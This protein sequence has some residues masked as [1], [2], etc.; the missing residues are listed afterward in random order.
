MWLSLILAG[1]VTP[2]PVTPSSSAWTAKKPAVQQAVLARHG[3]HTQIDSILIKRGYALVH[4][5]GFHDVLRQ[6]G[7]KWQTTCDLSKNDPNASVLQ[8]Q[9]G[10]P[11]PIAEVLASEEPVNIL[12]GQGNFSAALSAEQ[13]VS[14]SVS[15]SPTQSMRLQQLRTLNE[16]MQIQQITRSQAIAQW[17]QLEY[18]WFLP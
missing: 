13:G 8:S 15:Q 3:P 7:T 14:G 12:A 17:S 10:V 9:C 6:F 5:T 2:V 4:G 1:L 16:Q 11:A 18:S